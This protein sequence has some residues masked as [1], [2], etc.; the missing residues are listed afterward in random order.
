MEKLGAGKNSDRD[1]M[2]VNE[3]IKVRITILISITWLWFRFD[4]FF[5]LQGNLQRS[6]VIR[7][8]LEDSKNQVQKI[9]DHKPRAEEIIQRYMY[10]RLAKKREK[11]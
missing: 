5:L 11:L 9:F 8:G 3:L 6:K 2:R 4:Q 1:L 10:K 7:D